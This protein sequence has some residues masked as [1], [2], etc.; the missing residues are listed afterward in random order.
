MD[1]VWG[2]DRDIKRALLIKAVVIGVFLDI[3]RAYDMLWK[4]VLEV[5]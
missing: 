1:S 4:E 2:L 5:T 3:E